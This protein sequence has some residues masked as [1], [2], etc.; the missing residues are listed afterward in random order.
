MGLGGGGDNAR[1]FDRAIVEL[2]SGLKIVKSGISDAN[3][4][5]YCYVYDLLLRWA[6]DLGEQAREYNSRKA[7]RHLILRYLQSAQAAPARTFTRLFA[8]DPGLT[9]RTINEMLTD[10][11]LRPLRVLNGPGPTARAKPPAGGE[12]WYTPVYE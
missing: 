10:N 6:P 2:Q 1:R 7:M 8:W 11:A 3:R 4:W 5:K 9:E 12:I